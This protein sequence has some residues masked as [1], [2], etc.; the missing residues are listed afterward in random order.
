MDLRRLR[1]GEW[2]AA[3]AGLVLI[4]SLFL[5]WYEAGAFEVN[6]WE[7]FGLLD[8]LLF[9]SGAVGI[10]VL[11]ITAAQRTAAVGIATQALAFLVTAPIAVAT[12]WRVLNVPDDLNA[13]GA[14]RTAFAWIGLLSAIG[15]AAGT[16]VAMRDERVSRAGRPTDP[17]GVPVDAPPEIETVPAPPRGAA[18]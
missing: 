7:S 16:L 18:S 12:L 13:V 14:G 5:P 1:A 8:V 17:T 2:I 10:G 11:M 6:A 15:V 3:A 4:V 9:V